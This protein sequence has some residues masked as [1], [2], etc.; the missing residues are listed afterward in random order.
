MNDSM[1]DLF[2]KDLQLIHAAEQEQSR[3]LQDMSRATSDTET[4]QLLVEHSRET[5]AQ[6]RR[7]EQLLQQ[8]GSEPGADIPKA[9]QGLVADTE[10]MLALGLEGAAREIA[11]VNS[12]RKMEH[13]E[14]ACYGMLAATAQQLEEKQAAATLHE[15]LQ[16]EQR[17]E[18]RL[19]A[20]G[21]ALAK[22]GSVAETETVHSGD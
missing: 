4:K 20:I 5:D 12:A 22:S 9:V 17:A 18:E 15:I 19:S 1:R 21:I 3:H 11:L 8:F 13:F 2:I 10:D 6:A 7:L 14:I 16:Q